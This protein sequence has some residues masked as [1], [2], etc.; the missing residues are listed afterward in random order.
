MRGALSQVWAREAKG[1][2]EMR[3]GKWE[4]VV[5]KIRKEQ[6]RLDNI[7]SKGAGV[8]MNGTKMAA[9]EGEISTVPK[10]LDTDGWGGFINKEIMNHNTT[11]GGLKQKSESCVISVS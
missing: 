6:F 8:S 11:A 2:G 3:A 4:M 1:L 5:R 9:N 10:H 7:F